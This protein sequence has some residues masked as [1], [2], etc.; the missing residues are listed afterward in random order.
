MASTAWTICFGISESDTRR[1]FS[2]LVVMSVVSSGGRVRRDRGGRRPRPRSARRHRWEP[3]SRRPD[4]GRQTPR[5]HRNLDAKTPPVRSP[6]LATSVMVSPT[7]VNSPG[8]P[9]VARSAYPRSL[10]R[11]PAAAPRATGRGGFRTGARTRA[12][13]RAHA[14]PAAARRRCA[15]TSRS[16]ARSPRSPPGAAGQP[17]RAARGAGGAAC[18]SRP[19]RAW[20][21]RVS[22]TAIPA[23][24]YRDDQWEPGSRGRSLTR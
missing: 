16:S 22:D 11:S 9:G 21:G 8:W 3:A 5:L 24:L 23:G 6:P 7:R 4:R 10:R 13:R 17:G 15:R 1:R 14:R 2:R 18:G 12:A 20:R 19:G